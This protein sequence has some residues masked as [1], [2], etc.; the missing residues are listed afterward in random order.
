MHKY[1]SHTVVG[2]SIRQVG[3]KIET[4]GESAAKTTDEYIHKGQRAV[5]GLKKEAENY[6]EVTVD[7]V[8]KNPVKSTLI[9]AGVGIL[10]SRLFK[11]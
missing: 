4:F 1:N 3:H 10:L 6:G 5:I 7:Y 8:K 11:F 9:V 2:D